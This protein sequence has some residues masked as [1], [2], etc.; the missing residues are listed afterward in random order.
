MLQSFKW[1]NTLSEV[2][3]HYHGCIKTYAHKKEMKDEK[4]CN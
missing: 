4:T 3:L 2:T 1:E